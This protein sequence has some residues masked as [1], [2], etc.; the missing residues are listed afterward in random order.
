[1]VAGENRRPENGGVYVQTISIIDAK[2]H[3]D[4]QVRIGAWLTNKRSS[5]KIAF[6]QLRDGSA[7]FQGVVLKNNVS[8]EVFALAKGLKQETSLYVTGTIHADERSTL[9]TKLRLMTS[10]LSVK[11]RTTRLR[12]R[13]TGRTF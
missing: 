8:P 4:E 5:G 10:R 3:V 11:V 1:M 13:S 7:Y 6:L 2:D 9:A 12:P